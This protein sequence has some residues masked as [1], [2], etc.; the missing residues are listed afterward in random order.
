MWAGFGGSPENVR[1]RSGFGGAIK[2]MLNQNS[3]PV[4]S[5]RFSSQEGWVRSGMNFG[6]SKKHLSGIVGY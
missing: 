2:K 3:D 6:V 4:C 1:V 5:S